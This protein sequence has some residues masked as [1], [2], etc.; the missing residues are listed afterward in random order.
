MKKVNILGTEY[1]VAVLSREEDKF[2]KDCD[3]YCDKTS[4]K[5]VVASEDV[6]NELERFEEYQKKIIRHEIIHAF[7]IESGLQENFKHQEWGH[8]ETM[9]DWIAIQF[10]KLMQAF[11]E[12]DCI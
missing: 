9:I 5:I 8:D 3:G 2:L 10:P 7:L 6:D 4:K 12:V 11:K 1:S